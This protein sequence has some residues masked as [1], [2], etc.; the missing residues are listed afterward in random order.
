MMTKRFL[1]RRDFLRGTTAAAAGVWLGAVNAWGKNESPNNRLN[2]GIIGTANRAQSNIKGVES[3]NIVAVCDIDDIYLAAMKQRFPAAKSYN[4]FRK[5]LEQKHI[6]AVVIST[7]DHTHAVAT[8]AA[9][10]SGRHVYCEKPLAH[11]VAE[12]RL[13]A[14][15]AA[16]YKRAT[17][18]GTQIHATSNYRRVVEL[19]QAGAI[20]PVKE[21]HVWCEKSWSGEGRSTETPPVPANLHWDLWLGPAPARPYNPEYLPKVWRR[22]WDFGNGTL[23]DMGCHFLDLAHWAL[24]LRHPLTIEAE[25]P[26]ISA[27][28]TPA[29]L[30][31]HYEHD[32]REKLPPVRVTWYDGGRRP[33]LVTQGT[34]A[35]WKNGV[36]FV[37][38]KGMLLAD[39]A[40]HKLFPEQEFAGFVPPAQSIPDSIGH[41]EEWMQAC[42]TGSPTSCNFDYSGALSEA[43]LLGNVAYRTGRKIEWDADALKTKN[44]KEAMDYVHRE[45]RKGWSI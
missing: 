37:G 41:Y 2:I 27:E 43:V 24:K 17:Q 15:T 16:K 30:I 5:L 42:R 28:T 44:C 38:E 14:R 12:A 19:V 33:E 22:W 18:M 3:Q 32:A 23:G 26:P 45:Y 11:T 40:R 29:W 20:G 25:G 31:V 9:L 7:A 39:Y 10:K 21:C 35:N 36:L 34:V 1:T 6:D 4:D 8:V 13:A